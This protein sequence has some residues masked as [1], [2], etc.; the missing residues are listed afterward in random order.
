MLLLLIS[1]HVYKLPSDLN[2]QGGVHWEWKQQNQKQQRKYKG[3]DAIDQKQKEQ[4]E[5]FSPGA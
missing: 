3:Q 4:R 2:F 5:L 1:N